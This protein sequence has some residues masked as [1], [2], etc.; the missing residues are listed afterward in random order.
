MLTHHR[1]RALA[2]LTVGGMLAVAAAGAAQA[3]DISNSLD[4]TIDATAEVMS[5]NAGGVAGTTTLY[6]TPR[7]EAGGKNGCNLTGG[8]AL[9]LALGSSDTGVATVSPSSVTFTSCGDTKTLTVA[10]VGA[11]TTTISATQTANTT[12]GSFN[13][14]PVTFTVNVAPAAPSNTAPTIDV[15]GVTEGTSYAKGSVPEATCSVTDAEDGSRSFAATL[16]AV[17]GPYAADGIGAQT[18]TCSYTDAGGLSATSSATY[19]ITDP[20]APLV[21]YTLSPE[22]PDG[23][24]GWY[25]GAVTLRWSVVEAESPGSLTLVGCDDLTISSDQAAT[26]YRC[27]ATSA[28]GTSEV[29]TVPIQRDGT[30]PTVGFTSAS[31]QTGSN[32][33]YTGPVTAT[34][35]GT[36]ELSGPASATQT[37]MSDGEG[38]AV[39]VASPA[40][41]DRAG[42]TAP[43]GTASTTFKIDLTDPTATFDGTVPDVYFG[44]ELTAPTCTAAD[45]V[46]GGAGCVVTGFSRSVGTHTLV[47]TATDGAGRTG[48]ATQQYTVRPWSA[49]GFYAPVDRGIHNT[50]KAGSTVP[51]KFEL[52]AGET[53]ITDATKVTMSARQVTCTAGVEEDAIEVLGSGSTVLRY[54]ATGGQFIQNWKTPAK[55]GT[56]YAVTMTAADGSVLTATF[57]LK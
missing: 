45:E 49:R 27:A 41:T 43:A 46:S 20:T 52:F 7:N 26:S 17:D 44:A 36:D 6:V 40:F 24:G 10:P 25:R 19:A 39:V 57:K 32:G 11:G 56:C 38:L 22:Q 37:A 34:F 53:E 23:T 12:D 9:T 4:A 14:A 2:A 50:V 47:A 13:L 16:S 30:A 29:D 54:D 1:R 33:W 42:N 3:D 48:T 8:T 5:L 21:G 31:G 18:A 51:L 35:T 15:E 55:P 28:G